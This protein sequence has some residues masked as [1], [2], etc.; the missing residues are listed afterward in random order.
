MGTYER[1]QARLYG[2]PSV[3]DAVPSPGLQRRCAHGGD[4]DNGHKGDD[5]SEPF[6]MTQLRHDRDRGVASTVVY[7]A[8]HGGTL[9][10]QQESGEVVRGFTCTESC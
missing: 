5:V 3:D 4:A 7:L 10:F 9:G 8:A 1:C 2:V 6:S